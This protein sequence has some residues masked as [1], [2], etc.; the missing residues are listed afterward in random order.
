MKP[1][2]ENNN[3]SSSHLDMNSIKQSLKFDQSN[4]KA[5]SSQINNQSQQALPFKNLSEVS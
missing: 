3:K 2:Y 1:S 5:E 4:E